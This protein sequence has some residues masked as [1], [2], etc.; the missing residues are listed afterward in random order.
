MLGLSL[1]RTRLLCP[2]YLLQ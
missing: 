1:V 2:Y